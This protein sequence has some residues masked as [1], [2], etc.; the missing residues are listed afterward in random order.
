M[1]VIYLELTFF[2][3][4]K[5]TGGWYKDDAFGKE[6]DARFLYSEDKLFAVTIEGFYEV[7]GNIKAVLTSKYRDPHVL[8]G[9]TISL[10]TW[11]SGNKAV[12][13]TS[14]EGKM[15]FRF[16]PIRISFVN[17]ALNVHRA[18]KDNALKSSNF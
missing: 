12:R 8:V 14:T 15:E 4:N 6:V 18:A 7:S 10:T 9:S 2:L 1:K 11:R 17:E 13:I 5:V 3:E 16:E